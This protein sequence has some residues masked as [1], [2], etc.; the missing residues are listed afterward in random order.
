MIS[1]TCAEL[2]PPSLAA[3]LGSRPAPH[4]SIMELALM[5]KTLVS[6]LRGYESRKVGPDPCRLKHLEEWALCLD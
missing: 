4:L 5:A 1:K 2:A 3:A 6:Q